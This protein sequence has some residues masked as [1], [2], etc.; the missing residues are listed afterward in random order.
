MQELV[1][2]PDDFFKALLLDPLKSNRA[3][4]QESAFLFVR[5][6]KPGLHLGPG[7]HSL[8]EARYIPRPFQENILLGGGVLP[9][10]RSYLLTSTSAPCYMCMHS[11][12]DNKS[13]YFKIWSR[14]L[15]LG[16]LPSCLRTQ[17]SSNHV[18]S[19]SGYKSEPL[20]SNEFILSACTSGMLRWAEEA[21]GSAGAGITG[22][23]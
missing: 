5:G 10:L 2:A 12:C 6:L 19:L 16:S 4:G 7:K 3:A 11:L 13:F 20:K 14:V 21:V 18:P 22:Q 17:H 23:L 15:T 1:T 9:S 8:S